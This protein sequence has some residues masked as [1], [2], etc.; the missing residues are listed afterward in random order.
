VTG[1][2]IVELWGMAWHITEDAWA[3]REEPIRESRLRRD[4][5]RV[6]RNKKAARRKKD[7]I[8]VAWLEEDDGPS[9]LAD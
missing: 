8:D 2:T 7:L 9:D 4:V 3:F 1:R 6:I 5:V